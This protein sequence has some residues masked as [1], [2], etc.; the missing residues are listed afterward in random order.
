M[1]G[2]DRIGVAEAA[3]ALGWWLE[4][5]VDV[6]IAESPRNWLERKTEPSN[7]R[8]PSAEAVS[9][10]LETL[11]LFRDWLEK[12]PALPLANWLETSAPAGAEERRC[13]DGRNAD[14]QD[15]AK[16]ADRRVHGADG[17][18]A[19]AT[20][21]TPP[22]PIARPVLFHSP[23][24]RMSSDELGEC[25]AI[26]RRHIAAAKPQRLLLLGDSPARAL[27]GKPLA[28]ARGHVHKIEG[29]RAVATF[30]PRFLMNRPSDKALAWRDLLLLMER[31]LNTGLSPFSLAFASRHWPDPLAPVSGAPTSNAPPA[32]PSVP[33]RQ[34][35]LLRFR[36]ARLA[37]GVCS[38]PQQLGGGEP[39]SHFSKPCRCRRRQG[40][41]TLPKV[42]GTS[43]LQ[44]LLAEAASFQAERSLGLR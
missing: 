7:V 23:G 22:T 34:S 44:A 42:P 8:E 24:T 6:A 21:S 17:A 41:L 14:G 27:L 43:P 35:A 9:Q 33:R 29:V 40:R 10:A 32:T 30:H 26:A 20:A 25:A 5:G 18:D 2:D 13:A 38:D 37:R 11:D 36:S 4:A 31:G 12:A 19:G 15:A 39:A 28:A 3:S 16:A 1:G